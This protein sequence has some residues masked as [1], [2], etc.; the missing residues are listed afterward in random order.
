MGKMKNSEIY[1][2]LLLSTQ[3]SV[4]S[5][6]SKRLPKSKYKTILQ[7]QILSMNNLKRD[8]FCNIPG[9]KF[10]RNNILTGK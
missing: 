9:I 8:C 10:R 5:E 7:T 4:L 3:Y 6:Y 1:N 2:I